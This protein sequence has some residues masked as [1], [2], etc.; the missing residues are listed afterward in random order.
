MQSKCTSK[1][2]DQVKLWLTA[3]PSRWSVSH[4]R[5]TRRPI[6][7]RSNRNYTCWTRQV[8]PGDYDKVMQK[9]ITRYTVTG[10]HNAP[11]SIPQKDG[12]EFAIGTGSEFNSCTYSWYQ[13]QSTQ[14]NVSLILHQRQ[15]S[16]SIIA[17]ATIPTSTTLA[18]ESRLPI[19]TTSSAPSYGTFTATPPP[20]T[21]SCSKK[22]SSVMLNGDIFTSSRQLG[23]NVN[24][25]VQILRVH[26][27]T[28]QAITLHNNHSNPNLSKYC[29]LMMIQASHIVSSL[30]SG[31]EK[32]AL[33]C[34]STRRRYHP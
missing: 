25:P 28:S 33:C 27:R 13:H 16:K 20:F 7:A 12:H 14:H 2:A 32:E 8:K 5:F 15:E 34:K 21:S 17:E 30:P 18:T 6:Q 4:C 1:Y 29:L 22:T 11:V 24:G 10:K 9:C 23:Y 26:F 31:V 3:I 19:S